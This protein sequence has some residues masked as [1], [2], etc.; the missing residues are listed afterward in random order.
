MQQKITGRS[1][2]ITA[3]NNISEIRDMRDSVRENIGERTRK[4]IASYTRIVD[5]CSAQLSVLSAKLDAMSP[6]KILAR[7]Y[8]IATKQGKVISDINSV[9]SGDI[10][11][12]RLS[13]GEMECEVA[14]KK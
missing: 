5:S 10:I 2:P 6:L 11:N 7:G 4:N 12:V 9:E 3:K 13:N 8:S 1:E 14:W